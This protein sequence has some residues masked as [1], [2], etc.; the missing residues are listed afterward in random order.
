L[1][2]CSETRE[3]DKCCRESKRK[4][5]VAKPKK[6]KKQASKEEE[7]KDY[8]DTVRIT[9]IKFATVSSEGG[10]VHFKEGTVTLKLYKKSWWP[11]S[12]PTTYYIV[13]K[14][15]NDQTDNEV[16]FSYDAD[17]V[18]TSISPPMDGYA[19]L[20]ID[21]SAQPAV[22][23]MRNGELFYSEPARPAIKTVIILGQDEREKVR[24]FFHKGVLDEY[25]EDQQILQHYLDG[26][27]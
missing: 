6:E 2:D 14:G 26:R 23:E 22:R 8:D 12:H 1:D 11:R 25:D 21:K 10:N 4:K 27:N 24:G 7:D 5:R 15:E 20:V 9:D 19:A 13:V 3:S 16:Q 18:R 17:N